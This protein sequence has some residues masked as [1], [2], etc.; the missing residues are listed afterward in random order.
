MQRFQEYYICYF[1][2]YFDIEVG[3]PNERRASFVESVIVDAGAKDEEPPTAACVRWM[4]SPH[5]EWIREEREG[6]EV[7]A[8]STTAGLAIPSWGQC[9]R[10]QEHE[11]LLSNYS[12]HAVGVHA[13][14]QL[15]EGRR[16][17][18][19]VP[20]EACYRRGMAL[21]E[22]VVR[23]LVGEQGSL[24]QVWHQWC[25]SGVST[26]TVSSIATSSSPTP[27]DADSDIKS[28][29]ELGLQQVCRDLQ[30]EGLKCGTDLA[31]LLLCIISA[32]VCFN[33]IFLCCCFRFR[34][35]AFLAK[36]FGLET[37]GGSSKVAV[38][39]GS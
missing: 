14:L 37:P 30:L 20:S 21:V 6:L 3:S 1:N 25:Q 11:F 32:L 22:Q 31:L 39:V 8:Y 28:S 24:D 5:L 16:R 7:W 23:V 26:S 9:F 13:V 33:C 27:A 34:V 17:L 36:N 29:L 2:Q 35:S 12:L 15:A 4:C 19:Y 38:E 10:D 18:F